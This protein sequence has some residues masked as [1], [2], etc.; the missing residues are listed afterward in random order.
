MNNDNIL[1]FDIAMDNMMLMHVINP[2]QDLPH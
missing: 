1:R 2:D